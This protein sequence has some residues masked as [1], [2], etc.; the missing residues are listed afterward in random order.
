MSISLSVTRGYTFVAD[1]SGNIL[2]TKDRLNSLGLPTVE[3]EDGD[4]TTAAL[5][6]LSVTTDKLANGSVTT[7]KIADLNVTTDKIAAANVTTEKIA[8]ANITTDKIADANVTNAKLV[9]NS[10]MPVKLHSSLA[11]DGLGSVA[12]VLNVNPD[13]VTLGISADV[14]EVNTGGISSNELADD[15]VGTDELQDGAVTADKLSSGGFSTMN[16][17]TLNLKDGDE[18]VYTIYDADSENRFPWNYHFRV[19]VRTT[20]SIADGGVGATYNDWAAIDLPSNNGS[21]PFSLNLSLHFKEIRDG[22]ADQNKVELRLINDTGSDYA[23]VIQQI[24]YPSGLYTASDW[25][26]SS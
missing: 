1:G 20:T 17:F 22:G 25:G 3:I 13:N 4:I 9:D 21:N 24:I 7:I 14:L 5:A 2:V 11:G 15:S 6:N 19:W 12:G 10:I 16:I 8:D 23:L 18:Y 26:D